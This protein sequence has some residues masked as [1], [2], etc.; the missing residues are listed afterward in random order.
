MTHTT[1]RNQHIAVADAIYLESMDTCPTGV[2]VQLMNP[3]GVLVYGTW[4]G[5]SKVWQAW[6]PLPR[7]RKQDDT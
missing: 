3:G 5:K 1:D 6:A 2:K 7:R 4:D